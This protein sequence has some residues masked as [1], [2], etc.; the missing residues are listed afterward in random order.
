MENF[1]CVHQV[2]DLLRQMLLGPEHPLVAI[3]TRKYASDWQLLLQQLR[4]MNA[5]RRK[6]TYRIIS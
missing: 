4:L 6:S 2:V 3:V 5:L 1:R